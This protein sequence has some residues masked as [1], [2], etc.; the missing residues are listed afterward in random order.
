MPRERLRNRVLLIGV[1]AAIILI[2]GSVGFSLIEGYPPFD[3]FYMTLITMTTVGYS[4]IHQLSP[5]GRIFNIFVMLFGV[6]VMFFA[7]G[8]MTEFIIEIQL[9]EFFGR[10]R[11]KRMIHL[12]KDHYILCGFWRVGRGAAQ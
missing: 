5:E 4:E 8:V 7:I 12:L 3:A 2:I 10:R 1:M 6:S 11:M 9:G